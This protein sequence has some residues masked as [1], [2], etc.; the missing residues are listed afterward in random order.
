MDRWLARF[1]FSFFILAMVL[2]WEI[3]Q[4]LDGRRG[5]VAPWRIALYCVGSAI[6]IA[7]GAL[8][9]RARHRSMDQ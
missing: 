5:V 2:A 4:C 9:V 6:F 8:G 7:L 1:S 3:Y